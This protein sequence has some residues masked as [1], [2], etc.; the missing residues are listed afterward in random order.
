MVDDVLVEQSGHPWVED[1][2]AGW[3]VSSLLSVA[4]I[5]ERAGAAGLTLAA[6]RDL[7][8]LQRLGRPRDRAVR[9]AQP[10]LRA[11]RHRSAWASSMVGG[12]ALQRAHRAGLLEYRLLRLVAG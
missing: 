11:L 7:S 9:A 2:R 6:S 5:E 4:E 12:D 8:G 10:A 1:F 3:R